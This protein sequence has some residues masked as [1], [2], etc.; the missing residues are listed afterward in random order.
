V[1]KVQHK[2][3][4]SP[5]K[6]SN[7]K[8]KRQLKAALVWRTGL[9]G[10]PPDSVCCTKEIHSKLA[11]F[12]NLGSH[13][14]IIHRTVRC[15]KRSNGRQCNGR[16]QRSGDNAT[17]CRLRAQKSEQAQMAHRIVNRT[18]PVHHRTVQWPTCQKLQRSNPN[19][20][21]TWLAHRTVRCAH[22]QQSSPTAILVVGAINTPNHHSSSHPSIHYSSFNTRAIQNTPRHKS[23][24]PIKSK[25]TIQL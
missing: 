14:A 22:R 8:S 7:K 13:S 1:P 2:P 17:V 23:K 12:G 6:G 20:W 25:S 16:V 19:D 3:T 11:T 5:R 10:V 21:V 4:K 9:S 24:P 15:A 18:Y